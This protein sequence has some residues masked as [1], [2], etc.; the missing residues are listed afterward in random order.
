MV[1]QQYYCKCNGGYYKWYCNYSTH[2]QTH[3]ECAPFKK[4]QASLCLYFKVKKKKHLNV[5]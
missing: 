5:Y 2:I 3:S 4:Q 1:N